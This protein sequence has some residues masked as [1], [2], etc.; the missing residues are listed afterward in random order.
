MTEIFK[1]LKQTNKI[2]NDKGKMFSFQFFVFC[3]SVGMEMT[4][5]TYCIWSNIKALKQLCNCL[6]FSMTHLD[7]LTVDCSCS[8]QAIL[9]PLQPCLLFC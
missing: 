1:Q 9:V 7:S 5:S 3:L 4:D 6:F 2:A 8:T